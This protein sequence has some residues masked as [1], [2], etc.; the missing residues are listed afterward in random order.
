[1]A[2]WPGS[3]A[4]FT[5]FGIT[6]LLHQALPYGPSLYWLGEVIYVI[7]SFAA[8]AQLGFV[9][10]YQALVEGPFLTISYDKH[11][12][13]LIQFTHS[14]M[15]TSNHR[16]QRK[17]RFS[18]STPSGRSGIRNRLA[19]YGHRRFGAVH[20]HHLHVRQPE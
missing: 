10:L 4:L 20:V 8:K 18:A 12:S 3:F 19:L 11:P 5:F 7:L 9:V 15:V 1:M 2:R 17:Q 13:E 16:A 14:D 6:Q